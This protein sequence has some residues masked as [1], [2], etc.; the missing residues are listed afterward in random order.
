MGIIGYVIKDRSIYDEAKIKDIVFKDEI[1]CVQAEAKRLKT[2]GINIIIAA[3]H[4]GYDLDK[5]MAE[6]IEEIDL[7]VGGHSHTYLFTSKDGSNPPSIETPRGDYPT[8]VEQKSGKV[9]PVVQVFCYT[10]YLGHLELHFDADVSI[11]YY[12][13]NNLF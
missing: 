10:K 6:K 2:L 5:E 11:I 3:G 9:V 12:L 13:K 4:A 8:Y 1:E 7:V